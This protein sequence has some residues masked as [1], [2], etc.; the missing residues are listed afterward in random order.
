MGKFR[1]L[2][3]DD[4]V[5]FLEIMSRR[6]EDWGYEVIQVSSGKE[7]LDFVRKKAA[8]IVILDY[9]MPDMDGVLVLKEIRNIDKDL[10]VIMFTAHP[11]E[12]AIKG[13][14]YIGVDAFIPKVSAFQDT[15]GVLKS[16]LNI[17]KQKLS[18]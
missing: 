2:F 8:D 5:D 4:E 17:I 12:K 9:M 16:A 6:L 3:V 18:K 11:D 15:Q 1:I 7:A 13:S 10:A 14:D